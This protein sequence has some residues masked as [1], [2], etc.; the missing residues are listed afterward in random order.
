M[1]TCIKVIGIYICM[2]VYKYIY[3]YICTGTSSVILTRD[4][5]DVR[6]IYYNGS[7]LQDGRHFTSS[8]GYRLAF[9]NFSNNMRFHE[10]LMGFKKTWGVILF[11]LSPMFED[12]VCKNV[13]F[14]VLS[15]IC[16][17]GMWIGGFYNGSHIRRQWEY[18][19]HVLTYNL[20]VRVR[21]QSKAIFFLYIISNKH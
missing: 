20:H 16:R 5:P 19:E 2:C 18:L 8:L 17:R 3:M 9:F 11:F 21:I 1:K 13:A 7:S 4:L 6:K 14:L 12:T 15:P 10:D